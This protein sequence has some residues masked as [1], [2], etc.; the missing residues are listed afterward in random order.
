MDKQ[1]I[2]HIYSIELKNT[3][4]KVFVNEP[5]RPSEVWRK[6]L[7][8]KRGENMIIEAVSGTGKSSL[9]AYIFGSR[10]DYE[11]D[12]P[13]QRS[14]CA[15]IVGRRMAAHTPQQYSIPSAGIVSIPRN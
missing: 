15:R 6:N 7:T 12:I 5:Q 3:L 10:F 2:E 14:Q 8:F 9:C 13:F 4:P 11:G 1:T